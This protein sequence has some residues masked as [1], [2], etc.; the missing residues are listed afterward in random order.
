MT[1]EELLASREKDVGSG[2]AYYVLGV[3]VLV[4]I[5]NFV[6]RQIL[7][8]LAE[9][10]KADL[11]IDD[12]QMGF[13]YGTAFAVFYALFGIP[14][15]RLADMWV[16]KRL[17]AIGLTVWSSMTALSGLASS[18][19]QIAGARIGVGIG[20]ATASPA[21]F[22]MISDYFPKESRATALAIYSGGL[23]IGGGVS[24]FIGGAVAGNWN[25]AFPG[26]YDLAG[27]NVV[28]WQAAFMAV[29]IPGIL[30]A[31]WVATL[32]EPLRGMSEGTYQ[33]PEPNPWPKFFAELCSVIP[34]LTLI[35][36]ARGGSRSLINN[37]VAAV[38][39]AA[40]AYG[41]VMLVGVSSGNVLQFSALG[42]GAYA[43]F[44]WS[45]S[46]KR[47]D[48]ATYALIWGTPSFLLTLV[49]FGTIAFNTYAATF[50]AAP[51]VLRTFAD[52]VDP[53]MVGLI[54]GGLGAGGGFVGVIL[55]GKIS[56][57]LKRRNPAGRILVGIF[58]IV[59]MA[60]LLLILYTTDSLTIFYLV[61]APSN[62]VASMWVGVAAATSQDL[63]QP[64]MRGAATA[65]YFLGTT[66][67][68][69]GL[70]PWF[71]GTVSAETGDLAIGVMSLL[72]MVPVTL[73]CLFI[74]YKKLPEAEATKDA[75]AAAAVSTASLSN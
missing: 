15:G 39:I 31:L 49:G 64:R 50:W 3:L 34:P 37:I 22:S 14:L 57:I 65:T 60:P 32:R 66:L 29:G 38:V 59:A 6:D 63:V 8:I 69:L 46:I 62:I 42:I 41:I 40:G 1:D 13:L 71:A 27:F 53:A 17:M 10:I 16:R 72:L 18:F 12:G 28:G 24:L 73:L 74:L 23:Y 4:Y 61:S 48:P 70:G 9:D 55:G 56:D 44:S 35:D 26:G 21:A 45:Q 52:Q 51:Y 43:V 19:A 67:I 58:A 36:A 33:P 75:R 47:R 2:Y 30:V 68:G 11:G 25:E 54:L 20:E 7:S 5:L